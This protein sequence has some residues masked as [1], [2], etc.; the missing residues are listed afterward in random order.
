MSLVGTK[1]KRFAGAGL[2]WKETTWRKVSKAG[3]TIIQNI[4]S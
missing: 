2:N 3:T 1:L 4:L